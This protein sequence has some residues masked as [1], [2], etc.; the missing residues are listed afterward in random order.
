[1]WDAMPIPSAFRTD[2]P[3]KISSGTYDPDMLAFDV[4]CEIIHL[5]VA[6]RYS[7]SRTS[8]NPTLGPLPRGFVAAI[9]SIGQR[10]SILGVR[11][12]C[13]EGCASPSR[14]LILPVEETTPPST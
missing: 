13:G 4:A 12:R 5:C 2:T 9:C 14:R 6:L 7:E 1:M 10:G 11:G 3:N 8:V